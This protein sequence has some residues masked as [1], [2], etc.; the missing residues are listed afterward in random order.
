L[1]ECSQLTPGVLDAFGVKEKLSR[2]HVDPNPKKH[3]TL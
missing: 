3:D 1:Q 2:S